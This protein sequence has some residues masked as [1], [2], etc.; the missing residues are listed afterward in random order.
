MTSQH[1]EFIVVLCSP[2]ALT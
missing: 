2:D 1:L